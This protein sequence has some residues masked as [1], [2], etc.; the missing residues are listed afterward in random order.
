MRDSV[1]EQHWTWEDQ[2]SRLHL[3]LPVT[4]LCAGSVSAFSSALLRVKI[5]ASRMENCVLLIK[6]LYLHRGLKRHDHVLWFIL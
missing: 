4:L 6:P 5:E 3:L 1:G 2:V